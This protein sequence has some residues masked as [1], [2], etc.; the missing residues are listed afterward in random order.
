MKKI[1]LPGIVGAVAMF[2]L[3]MLVGFITSHL[4]PSVMAEYQNTAVFRSMTDPHM[5]V[6]Y[7]YPL[8]ISII[9]AWVYNMVK[10]IIKKGSSFVRGFK[11]GAVYWLLTL[12]GLIITW[13][14]FQMS[15]LMLCVWS[16]SL[17]IQFIIASWIYAAMNK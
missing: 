8:V 9:L 17:F 12:M 13:G 2:I 16:V 11:F 15:F 14:T 6:F 4:F 3:G 5:L 1:L 10:P 7:F